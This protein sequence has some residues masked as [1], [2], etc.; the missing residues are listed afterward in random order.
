[1]LT[2]RW[3]LYCFC[4]LH[5]TYSNISIHSI[6]FKLPALYISLLSLI[7]HYIISPVTSTIYKLA[8]LRNYVQDLQKPLSL[9]KQKRNLLFTIGLG[10]KKHSLNIPI[11]RILTIISK[12]YLEIYIQ[13]TSAFHLCWN[14]H[15]FSLTCMSLNIFLNVAACYQ[16]LSI[17]FFF[18]VMSSVLISLI[19]FKVSI[20]IPV[21][22]IIIIINYCSCLPT[23]VTPNVQYE[24]HN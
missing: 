14:I 11:L 2:S 1:M 5:G 13:T 6:I 7:R 3:G 9:H 8:L 19:G 16:K 15:F 18:A 12:Y 17:I 24:C 20:G 4:T 10:K 23:H 21:D 22:S